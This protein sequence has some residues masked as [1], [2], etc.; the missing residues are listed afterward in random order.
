MSSSRSIRRNT[1]THPGVTGRGDNGCQIPQTQ[2]ETHKDRRVTWRE[3]AA[4][5]R[6]KT[7]AE[8]EEDQDLA[9]CVFKHKELAAGD[10]IGLN[11]TARNDTLIERSDH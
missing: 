2:S 7:D 3:D 5:S 11:G 9:E 4:L 8:G 1:L 10:E 6:I